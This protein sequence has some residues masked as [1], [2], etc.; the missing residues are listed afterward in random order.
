M[1]AFTQL[2]M[3]HRPLDH[4]LE[5]WGILGRGIDVPAWPQGSPQGVRHFQSGA[6]RLSH[7]D[8]KDL[9]EAGA[10]LTAALAEEAGL[11]MRSSKHPYD[12]ILFH[13]WARAR[14]QVEECQQQY[15]ACLERLPKAP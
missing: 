2:M 12:E 3:T 6:E 1:S 10:R 15:L 14:Q 8:T 11:S 7:D 13:E 4:Y 5:G 9:Y